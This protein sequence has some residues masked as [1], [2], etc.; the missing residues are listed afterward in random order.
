[1]WRPTFL[2]WGCNLV[3]TKQTNKL[4][5]LQSIRETNR[6]KKKKKKVS[7]PASNL[8]FERLNFEV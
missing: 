7:I 5:L 2:E 8:C 3:S 4:V 6:E 1:M